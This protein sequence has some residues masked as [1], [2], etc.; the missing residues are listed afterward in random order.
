LIDMKTPPA[1]GYVLH[2]PLQSAIKGVKI[3]GINYDKFG[4]RSLN[5]PASAKTVVIKY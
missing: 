3:D 1:S 2:I 5:L 4:E